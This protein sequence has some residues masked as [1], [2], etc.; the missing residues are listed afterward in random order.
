MVCGYGF[1][2]YEM[3]QYYEINQREWNDD[4]FYNYLK[5]MKKAYLIQGVGRYNIVGKAALSNREKQ[6][7]MSLDKVDMSRDGI[8]HMNIIDFLLMRKDLILT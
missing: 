8:V 1:L 7:V 6:Y 5:R 4:L 3:R 2:F